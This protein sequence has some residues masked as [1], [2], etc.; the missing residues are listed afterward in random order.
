MLGHLDFTASAAVVASLVAA[1]LLPA[2]LAALARLPAL[3]DRNALQF[4]ASSVIVIAA[5]LIALQLP[6]MPAPSTADIATSLMILAGAL[7]V[8]LEA[9]A[10]L[11]RGYTLGLL[12]TLFRAKHPMNDAQLA[13]SYRQG[14]GVGW[15]MR[16]RLGGLM[17]ARLVRRQGDRIVLT[18]AGAIIGILYR[19]AIAVLGLKV[20]G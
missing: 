4:L 1:A 12:L 10:L 14:Q 9:W 5:W 8:Y 16:H 15:I 2:V 11:S 6:A 17:S 3:R 18:P 13:A 20:T 7:L 19:A